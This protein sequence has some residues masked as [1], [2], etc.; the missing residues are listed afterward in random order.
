MEIE[1]GRL[2]QKLVPSA[3]MVRFTASGTEATLMALRLARMATGRPKVLK[4]MGH[5]HGWH[6]A[7]M[8]GAYQPYDGSPVD[9]IPEAVQRFTVVLPPNDLD[10]VEDARTRDPETGTVILGPTRAPWGLAPT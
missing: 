10:R 5:F 9:G 2:V 6:D 1:W 4:F 7:V 3:D 8:P